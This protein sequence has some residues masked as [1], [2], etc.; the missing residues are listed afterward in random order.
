MQNHVF[1]AQQR[2]IGPLDGP[3]PWWVMETE[4]LFA[5]GELRTI[6]HRQLGSWIWSRRGSSGRWDREFGDVV[7]QGDEAE[8]KIEELEKLALALIGQAKELLETAVSLRELLSLEGGGSP[9][10]L[11]DGRSPR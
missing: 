9:G 10:A 4:H 7:A 6:C 5:Y 3:V 11:A 1:S 8:R 2:G